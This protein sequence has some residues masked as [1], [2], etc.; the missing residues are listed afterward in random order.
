M[1][2]LTDQALKANLPRVQNE[3]WHPKLA[4]SCVIYQL[5]EGSFAVVRCVVVEGD[6]SYNNLLVALEIIQLYTTSL[7]TVIIG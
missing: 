7:L 1:Q 5:D 2:H 4:N 3:G 6:S